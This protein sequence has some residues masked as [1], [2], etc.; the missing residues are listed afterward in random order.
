MHGFPKFKSLGL[1]SYWLFKDSVVW[2]PR[3]VRHV[4]QWLFIIARQF[5]ERRNY[6]RCGR[7]GGSAGFR[8]IAT[9]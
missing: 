2:Q 1:L 6:V 4:S 8:V 5:E 9:C 3:A 7:G